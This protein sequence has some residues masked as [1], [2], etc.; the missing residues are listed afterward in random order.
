L[1]AILLLAAALRF[2]GLGGLLPL[3]NEYFYFYLSLHPRNFAQFLGGIR[4]NPLHLLLSQLLPYWVALWRDS[5]GWLRLPSALCGCAGVWGLWRL[6]GSNGRA[7]RAAAASFLLAVSLLH[8]EWSTRTDLYA[9]ASA[10]PL[11]STFT[12][13]QLP[14]EAGFS[15]AYAAWAVLLIYSSPYAAPLAVLH[16]MALRFLPADGRRRAARSAIAAWAAAFACFVPW[17]VFVGSGLG[18]MLRSDFTGSHPGLQSLREFLVRIPLFFAQGGEV[19]KDLW[20]WGAPL[21]G[22]LAALYFCCYLA[23][24]IRTSR[25][26]GDSVVRFAHIAVP[27]GIATVTILDMAAG[28]YYSHRQLLWV[29]PFYLIGAADGFLWGL[30]RL[31]ERFSFSRKAAGRALG[32]AAFLLLIASQSLYRQTVEAQISLGKGLQ[33]VLAELD[34]RLRPGDALVFENARLAQEFLYH[35]DRDSFR[36]GPVYC[37]LPERMR[38]ERGGREY[39]LRVGDAGA[40]KGLG[41]KA[42]SGKTWYFQGTMHDMSVRVPPGRG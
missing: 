13:F 25:G 3:G 2:H 8:I 10:L 26:S 19:T 33:G 9:L 21:P 1:G 35:F 37:D 39:E 42:S 36:N 31:V 40:P 6:A 15:W 20:H 32:A 28:N 29:L 24:L 18:A 22:F 16:V 4:G 17:L 27:W 12:F 7:R 5:P 30:D 41:M 11:F 14:Q 38:V 34:A 23:S